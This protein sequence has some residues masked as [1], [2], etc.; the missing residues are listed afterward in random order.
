MQ[1]P[2]VIAGGRFREPYYWDSYWILQGLLR[3]GGNFTD[4]SRNQIENFLDDVEEFG[5]VPNGNRRYYL[6]RSQPPVLSQMV[7]IYIEFTGDLSILDR[8]VPLLIREQEFFEKNRT[9]AVTVGNETYTLNRYVNLLC[10][11]KSYH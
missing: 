5:F 4:I 9:A 10:L 6:N 3:T 1:R 8:A 7:R 11:P 2:F